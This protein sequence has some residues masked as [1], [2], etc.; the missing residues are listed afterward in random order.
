MYHVEMVGQSPEDVTDHRELKAN[1]EFRFSFEAQRMRGTRR[2]MSG[3]LRI[4]RGEQ[5]DIVTASDQLLGN[6]RDYAF[7]AAVKLGWNSFV[8]GRQ[9]GDSQTTVRVQIGDPILCFHYG[10]RPSCKPYAAIKSPQ[11]PEA[12]RDEV[13]KFY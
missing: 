11:D 12:T 3:S 13:S 5:G 4:T 2:E 9:L 1:T 10:S 6:V 7:R 8:E